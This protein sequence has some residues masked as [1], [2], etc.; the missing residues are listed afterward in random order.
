MSECH[1]YV[2]HWK[3]TA[4]G[5]EGWIERWPKRHVSGNTFY[6]MRDALGDVVGEE[7]GDGEPQFEFEPPFIE[8]AGWEHLFRDG[9]RSTFFLSSV[10]LTTNAG[11]FES[12]FCERC[13]WPIGRRTSATLAVEFGPW[14]RGIKSFSAVAQSTMRVPV[15]SERLLDVFTAQERSTF[16]ARPVT[17]TGIVQSRFYEFVP[18]QFVS[19]VG[20]KS[21]Q[22]DGWHC[23][24]CG[25]RHVSNGKVLG[26]GSEVVSRDAVEP[27]PGIVFL[28]DPGHFSVCFGADRWEAVKSTLR[29]AE[30]TSSPIA[31]I[32]PEDREDSP[33]LVEYGG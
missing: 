10:R 16:E 17:I 13:K 29:A 26:Y 5:Y 12:G 22:P 4:R 25:R 15:A 30:I 11:I 3:H 6:E 23:S 27:T 24:G 20:G 2:C 1:V 21:F 19:R 7:V 14:A 18:Q 33:S 32:E 9:W 28:G 8:A 31:I